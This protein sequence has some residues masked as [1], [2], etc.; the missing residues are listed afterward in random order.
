MSVS[1]ILTLSDAPERSD[2][3]LVEAYLN[4]NYWTELIRMDDR[5]GSFR[6]GAP[7]PERMDQQLDEQ[8]IGTFAF[9]SAW[10]PGSQPLDDWHNRWRNLNMEL[11]LHPH[12]RLLR[13]GLGIGETGD[14]PP[15]ESFWA[16]GIAPDK[17]VEIARQFGQ[18][19]LVF[20]KKG[21]LP[22]LWWV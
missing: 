16:L 6:V 18:N 14:W 3:R 13:R 8:Q 9:L 20:W 2:R 21:S 19:A 15:E 7:L 5:G 4:T 17:A 10:N 22:A 11:E 12:C 1:I